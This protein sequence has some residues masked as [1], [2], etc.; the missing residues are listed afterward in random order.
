MFLGVNLR[1]FF[2]KVYASYEVL[3]NEAKLIIYIILILIF[4]ASILLII[5]VEQ[6]RLDSKI[7]NKSMRVSENTEILNF[8]I[9]DIDELNEKTRNL[10]EITDKIQAVID[11][12]NV[13]LTRFE[14][15]QEEASIISYNELMKAVGKPVEPVKQ[16]DFSLPNLVRKIEVDEEIEKEEPYITPVREEKFKSSIFISPVFGTQDQNRTVI[17]EEQIPVKKREEVYLQD[18]FNEEEA[19]LSNLRNFRKN[20]E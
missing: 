1:L 19:F 14:Q 12:R 6:R 5:M 4:I 13:D 15:D 17:K 20:L 2:D 10:K 8:N 3:P 9:D 18:T 11:N 16:Q 7:V